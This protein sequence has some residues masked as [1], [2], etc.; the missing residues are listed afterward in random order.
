MDLLDKRHARIQQYYYE[1]AGYYLD[2]KFAGDK[3]A[4]PEGTF[5]IAKAYDPVFACEKSA[6]EKTKYN[7][8]D[9]DGMRALLGGVP[10]QSKV[11]LEVNDHLVGFVE[12]NQEV[13]EQRGG[14]Y[15]QSARSIYLSALIPIPGTNMLERFNAGDLVYIQKYNDAKHEELRQHLTTYKREHRDL[16]GADDFTHVPIYT[17]D[18]SNGGVLVGVCLTSNETR[19]EGAIVD[20]CVSRNAVIQD[21]R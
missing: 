10:F 7:E 1:T 8:S 17:T 20:F 4:D 13:H 9:V 6:K 3:F 14:T 19:A 16:T 5:P 12:R 2:S 11:T 18:N 15:G 21:E